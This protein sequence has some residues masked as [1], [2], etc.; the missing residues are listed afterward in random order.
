RFGNRI[1]S[2]RN[3]DNGPRSILRHGGDDRVL[4]FACARPLW[5]FEHLAVEVRKWTGEYGLGRLDPR[6]WYPLIIN[7]RQAAVAVQRIR[8]GECVAYGGEI[9]VYETSPDNHRP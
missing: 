3:M 7:A 4:D 6:S 5:D 2:M 8:N 1:R 9:G